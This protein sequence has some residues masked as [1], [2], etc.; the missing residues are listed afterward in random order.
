MFIAVGKGIVFAKVALV[1]RYCDTFNITF[2][3]TD[4]I[5]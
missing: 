3:A 5:K 2:I 1:M 4:A